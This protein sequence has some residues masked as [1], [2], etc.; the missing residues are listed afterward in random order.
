VKLTAGVLAVNNL[1]NGGVASS[2]TCLQ[3]RAAANL[4]FDGGTL[5]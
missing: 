1:Q 3:Q 4:D 5:R 2:L